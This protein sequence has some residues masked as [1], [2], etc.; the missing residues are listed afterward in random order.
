MSFDIQELLEDERVLWTDDILRFRDTD[1][2]RHV[3]NS[4]YAVLAESGRVQYFRDR[5]TPTVDDQIYYIV[6][7]LT[8]DFRSELHYP[9]GVRT[10]TWLKRLGR[11]SLGVGQI[12]VGDDGARAAETEA[13]CVMMDRATR[14]P[15]ALPD[16]TR[17]ALATLLR[18][19]G[20]TAT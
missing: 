8:I 12:I 17:A 11:S 4:I 16:A 9:G 6:A 7:R 18:E 2:N 19:D 14:R 3:N 10:A 15:K 1:M 13:V 5:I 20:S